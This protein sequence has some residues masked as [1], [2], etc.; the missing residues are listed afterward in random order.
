MAFKQVTLYA[1]LALS[2]KSE[3]FLDDTNYHSVSTLG[4]TAGDESGCGQLQADQVR[5]GP[6]TLY[7]GEV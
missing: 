2:S 3:R 1:V 6:A 5:P 7:C 4:P